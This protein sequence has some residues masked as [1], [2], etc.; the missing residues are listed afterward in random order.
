MIFEKKGLFFSIKADND[1]FFCYFQITMVMK[2]NCGQF[3][4]ALIHCYN[5]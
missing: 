2:Y 5:K 1:I 3:L 4:I